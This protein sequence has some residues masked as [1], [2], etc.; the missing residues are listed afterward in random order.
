MHSFNRVL[1]GDSSRFVLLPVRYPKARPSL[2]HYWDAASYLLSQL[3][4]AYKE[5]HQCLW[6]PNDIELTVDR[7]QWETGLT[8]A[9]RGFIS[10]ILAFFAASDGLVVDNLAQRFCA[11]V[12]LPEARC[13]Y[14]VQMMM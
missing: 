2:P 12:Q 8:T 3:W 9:E 14:G 6:A 4:A 10:T 1:H 7:V 11:E 5:A 13:F